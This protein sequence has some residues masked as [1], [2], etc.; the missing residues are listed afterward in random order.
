M[1]FEACGESFRRAMEFFPRHFPH[2]P[3]EAFQ[4]CSWLLSSQLGPLLPAE[5][6]IRRLQEEVYLFPLRGA[7]DEQLFERAFGRKYEDIRQA[8]RDTVLRR[9]VV[10]HILAGGHFQ[11]GG[12]LLW[13]QDVDWG[14]KVYRR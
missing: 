10:D 11:A 4:C 13:P 7:G 8:P 6:N 14:R 3:F 9:A 1:A 2:R 12:C 5:S